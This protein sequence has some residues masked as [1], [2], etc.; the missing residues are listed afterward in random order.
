[1]VSSGRLTRYPSE[2][3]PVVTP[4]IMCVHVAHQCTPL[5]LK[6]PRL[7]AGNS[8]FESPPLMATCLYM[9][10]DTKYGIY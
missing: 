6:A 5:L 2:M 10:H 9:R 3:T 1:M 8:N 4:P 7:A